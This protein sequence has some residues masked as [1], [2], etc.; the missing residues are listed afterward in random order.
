MTD[1]MD[2]ILAVLEGEEDDPIFGLEEPKREPPKRQVETG[3]SLIEPPAGDNH[4]L[5][6]PEVLNSLL[7]RAAYNEE[8]LPATFL[9]NAAPHLHS[10]NGIVDFATTVCLSVARGEIKTAQSSELRKW[11]ELMYTCVV[12]SQ[13]QQNNVQVNYVEQ[14][15]Q[16]AGGEES[17]QPEV[18]DVRDA[19][20]EPRKKAQGE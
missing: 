16:L 9:S 8:S 19:I 10:T 18:L 12:A 4:S 17:M 14:L 7:E 6:S 13:P 3:I 15:I 20:T 5:L 2:E 11:A 1:E